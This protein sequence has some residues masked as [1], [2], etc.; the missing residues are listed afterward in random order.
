ME[1]PF[2]EMEDEALLLA[3]DQ[4]ESSRLSEAQVIKISGHELASLSF[5]QTIFSNFRNL[6]LKKIG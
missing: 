5:L 4:G 2:G 3:A 1:D 6:V